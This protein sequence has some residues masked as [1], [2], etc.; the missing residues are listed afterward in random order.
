M[1]LMFPQKP[2]SRLTVF[3]NPAAISRAS[4]YNRIF[5]LPSTLKVFNPLSIS[6]LPSAP[7]AAPPFSEALHCIPSFYPVYTKI[8]R[9][10]QRLDHPETST[11]H[12][13]R[14]SCSLPCQHDDTASETP[15]FQQFFRAEAVVG[16]ERL[17][18]PGVGWQ[19]FHGIVGG[20]QRHALGP[21]HCTA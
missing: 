20:E 4:N 14:R 5:Y 10:F 1:F 21:D 18:N 9:F 17:M 3:A 15:P 6:H 11:R 2:D 8:R 13:R 19:E 16:F 12:L 7:Q